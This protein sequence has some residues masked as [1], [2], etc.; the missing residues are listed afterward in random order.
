MT[1]R[2][3]GPFEFIV[4]VAL[5]NALTAMSIDTMLPAIGDIATELGAANPNDRQ[6]IITLFFAGMMF[7]TLIW[8]P[9]SDATGRRPAIFMSLAGYAIGTLIC[10]FAWSFPMVILG[11][12]VQGFGA[13]G[14]RIV[15]IAMVR[16]GQAGAAMARVMSFVMSV[17]M[18]VP[19]LAPSAG[20]LILFV[21]DWRVIFLGFLA[22]GALSLAW[23]H[24]RQE[25]TLPPERRNPLQVST[26]FEAAWQFLR[27]PVALGYTTAVGF[28]FAAF[29]NYL[30][31]SQQIFAEQ[32]AQGEL[33]AV[34]FG[35]FAV[36]IACAMIFN[37]RLVVKLGMRKLSKYALRGEIVL[38]LV[39]LIPAAI[40]AGHPP[41]WMLGAYLFATF[42]CCGILFGNYNAM[43]MEPMGRIAGMAAAISGFL[44][45][46]V[47][48]AFGGT[49]GQLYNGTVLPLVLG[50]GGF[51]L[52]AL[53]L[54]EW[55]ERR[56]A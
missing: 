7:G 51:G 26:M 5:L 16:D 44:S 34:W 37:G 6:L 18:L 9:L 12:F 52:L 24:V 20:Q 47:A 36:A 23:L 8:G 19:I 43:A 3:I 33:F 35:V 50:Y 38:A 53:L 29:I 17:F 21:A 46:L 22:I 28:I 14:P 10:F 54:S 25:E 27:H 42:F 55:A 39:F 49:L 15:S 2:K 45:T 31:T 4:L 1:H 56:R 13:A 41:L 48:I 11:R 40:Y 32:Y 30:S